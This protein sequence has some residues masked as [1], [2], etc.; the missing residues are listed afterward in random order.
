MNF[1]DLHP[2]LDGTDYGQIVFN[3]STEKLS[4]TCEGVKVFTGIGYVFTQAR[5]HLPFSMVPG[6][7]HELYNPDPETGPKRK[8]YLDK[9]DFESY[10]S[11]K[12]FTKYPDCDHIIIC[13]WNRKTIDMILAILHGAPEVFRDKKITVIHGDIKSPETI[14]LMRQ[15]AEEDGKNIT[16]VYFTNIFN[17]FEREDVQLYKSLSKSDVLLICDDMDGTQITAHTNTGGKTK[18]RF[19]KR[20]KRRK[21]TF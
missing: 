8:L 2:E 9:Y 18:R 5:E 10:F 6:T 4:F 13:D 20:S 21:F 12:T 11:S 15:L 16:T 17:V 14:H 1:I 7:Y 19:R 3:R